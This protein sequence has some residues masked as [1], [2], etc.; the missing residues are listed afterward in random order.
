M[1]PMNEWPR[2]SYLTGLPGGVSFGRIGTRGADG[3]YGGTIRLDE[4]YGDLPHFTARRL[5]RP[6]TC[7][8]D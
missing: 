4:W 8:S 6:S 5:L 7:R 2:S 1:K 3:V